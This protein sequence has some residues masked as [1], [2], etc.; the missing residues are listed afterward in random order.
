MSAF[1]LDYIGKFKPGTVEKMTALRSKFI[2]LEGEISE[3]FPLITGDEDAN[4]C[5]RVFSETLSHLEKS[6][7]YAI[8]MLCLLNEENEST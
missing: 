8:K 3:L 6:Q 5:F 2:E 1:R 4:N 7:M